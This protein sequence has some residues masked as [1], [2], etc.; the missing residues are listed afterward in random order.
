MKKIALGEIASA[1][2]RKYTKDEGFEQL[3]SSIREHGLIEPPV[4]RRQKEGGYK[5][6]AGRRR[7]AALRQINEAPFEEVLCVVLD[8]GDSVSD[9]E[10]ALAE[11]V[12]RQEMHPLDEAALFQNMADKGSSVE[13]IARH[14]A[15]SPA[16]IYKRLRLCGLIEE[17]KVMFRDGKLNIA[18]AAVLAELPEED[19]KD[20][21]E[22]YKH[23][24][25]IE[26]GWITGFIYKKQK[27][28]IKASMEGCKNCTKRT[29]NDGNDLFEE[30][31]H[32]SDVCL[33]ADCYRSKWYEMINKKLNEQ[34]IQMNEA[35]VKT[36]NKIYFGGVPELLYKNSTHA[37][38]TDNGE[39][40][41]YEVMRP[42]GYDFTGETSRKKETCWRISSDYKGEITVCRI[43]YKALAPRIKESKF[44]K[45]EGKIHYVGEAS[46]VMKE[47]A[48]D[49][50]VAAK[51]LARSLSD[52]KIQFNH[53]KNEID[54][55]VFGRI[56]GRRME[57]EISGEEPVRDYLSM[58]LHIVEEISYDDVR[59][60]EKRFDLVQK[61]WLSKLF[62]KKTLSKIVAGLDEEAQKLFH[63][64]TLSMGLSDQVPSLEELED[65]EESENVFWV[66][67]G[68]SK[69]EYK[70]LYV[71]AAKEV[72]AKALN[73]KAKKRVKNKEGKNAAAPHGESEAEDDCSGEE[74]NYPFGP[75]IPEEDEDMENTP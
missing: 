30:Y 38:F 24:E 8:A 6:V 58:F 14:Y 23:K 37:R 74:D 55:L 42:K 62:G 18:G 56:V 9:E 67:A 40:V 60:I 35:G 64:L 69:E 10:I 72:T 53:F 12:N 45:T 15:R 59:L 26:A 65:I 75:D 33:D 41:Q 61:Q 48:A 11:N 63:F 36:D 13:D 1:D 2:N 52:K 73:P 7:I 66:Y 49:R 21:F 57:M 70:A 68:M 25:I 39:S 46:E 43:G 32:L 27:L 51:E 28:S 31:N 5:V 50:G 34:I 71:E 20:F 3:V 54:D 29:H 16:A 44:E 47:V 22:L 19:Q 17:L 4:V